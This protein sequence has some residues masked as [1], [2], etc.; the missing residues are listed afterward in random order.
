MWVRIDTYPNETAKSETEWPT[1][2]EKI[3]LLNPKWRDCLKQSGKT[4]KS[5]FNLFWNEILKKKI[6][7]KQIDKYWKAL[8]NIYKYWQNQHLFPI[9]SELTMEMENIERSQLWREQLQKTRFIIHI[10]IWQ[11]FIYSRW[12]FSSTSVFYL[13]NRR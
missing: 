6:L 10:P 8:R 9:S 7:K 4:S 11:I 12:R 1:L 2:I 5:V 3:G 13:S